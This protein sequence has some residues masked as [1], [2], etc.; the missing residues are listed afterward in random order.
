MRSR[1][2]AL[3]VAAALALAAA[4]FGCSGDDT[5][6]PTQQPPGAVTGVTTTVNS[7]T[8]ITVTWAAVTGATSY[9]VQ[10]AEGAS[11]TFADV[12]TPTGTSFA[13]TGLKGG[14]TYRYKVAAANAAGTG[15]FSTEAAGTTM[16]AGPKVATVT[17]NITSSRTFSSDTLYVLRGFV[18]VTN[19]ATLT[20]QPGTKIVG[21]TTAAGSSLWITR[22]AKIN[23]VGTA[24][25]PIVFTSQRAPG[26]RA[27]GDW[28]GLVIVGN[29]LDNRCVTGGVCT[30]FTEGP[31][32][33]GQDVGENY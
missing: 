21:D 33:T 20:I 13:D 23:A 31:Q 17:G 16:T 24:Q 19:G 25:S 29:A 7:P 1:A 2:R 4:A 14:T 22:G 26:N 11:G 10:R 8:S 18:K 15:S 12:A 3:Q 5:T 9:V 32:G 28:G 30:L 27:P 6:E